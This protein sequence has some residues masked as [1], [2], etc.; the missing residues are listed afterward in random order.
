[1]AAAYRYWSALVFGAVI[2][3][4]G[5]AGYGAFYARHKADKGSITDSKIDHG[6]GAHIALGYLIFLA[7]IILLM[8][9]LAAPDRRSRW[10]PS[11]IL[12]VL[13]A[14]Q[15][16]LAWIGE[17]VP[18]VGFFHPLTALA[19]VGL[20]GWIAHRSWRGVRAEAPAAAAA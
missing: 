3:Q 4:V 2:V 11:V 15:V 13:L 19:I 16:V 20:S 17:S 5:L 9:A 1:M 12:A 6:F 14:V 10:K 8:I 7:G 18:A